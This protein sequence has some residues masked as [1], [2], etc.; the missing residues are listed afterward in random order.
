MTC[1]HDDKVALVTGSSR[2]LG[3][4]IVRE[5][6]SHGCHTVINYRQS[7]EKA[8]A[9]S[10]ETRGNGVRS[11]VVGADV[12][13]RDEVERMVQQTLVAFGHVDILIN[14]AG[15]NR[16]RALA[17]MSMEQWQEV[18][19]T[20]LNSVFYCTSLVVPSMIKQKWGRI[21][22]IASAVGQMG[23]I[24]QSN[25]A[26]TK[27]GVVGF[28]KTIALELARYNITANA[29]SPGFLA[30]DMVLSLSE[31]VQQAILARIPVGRLGQPEE[32]ARLCR[33]L[34]AEGDYI[35]GAQIQING[36]IYLQ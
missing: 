10:S 16:D 4:A 28:T 15:I 5:L 8:E 24:G 18:I 31:D 9:L 17:R 33:F 30:T 14:N 26:A 35:T 19:E 20:N 12:S 34:V 22:S 29:I 36:G 7:R 25:Y 23:N 32:I 1:L 21:V 3:A 13:R 6:A 27:A 11:I 2:G